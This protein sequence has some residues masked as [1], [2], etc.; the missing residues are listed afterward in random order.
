MYE[1]NTRSLNLFSCEGTG[2]TIDS[3][4]FAT[5]QH[6]SLGRGLLLLPD[7]PE[8]LKSY[9]PSSLQAKRLEVPLAANSNIIKR[10][11]I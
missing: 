9:L 2:Q 10:E 11:D 8:N 7:I 4:H 6:I 1:E 5:V 3:P